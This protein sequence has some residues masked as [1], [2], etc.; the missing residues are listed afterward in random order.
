MYFKGKVAVVTGGASGIGRASCLSLGEKGATVVAADV[1]WEAAKRTTDEIEAHGGKAMAIK[2]DVCKLS[3]IQ[4]AVDAVVGH[5]KKIDIL[6]N[7]AGICQVISVDDMTEKD[8]DRMQTINLKST[9]F[10]SQ[11]VIKN[12]KKN[13]QGRIVNIGSLAG[14]VGGITVGA[15]YAVSKAG[16]T[17]LSKSLAKDVARYNINVNTVSPGFIKTEMTKDLGQDPQMV[18]LGRIG[19]PEEVADV[20]VF[21]CSHEAR[22]ITGANIDVN[23]GLFMG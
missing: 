18:P 15:N 7:C 12:M 8:W 11:A 13:R 1:N 2:V 10:M 14:E 20:I 23:G 21:L 3:E 5:F 9:F 22:Y 17:C 16:I 6:I 4:A 19:M